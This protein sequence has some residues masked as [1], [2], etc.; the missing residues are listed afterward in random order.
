[1]SGTA[2]R[3]Y[4]LGTHDEELARLGLQHRVWRPTALAC[5]HRAGVTVGSRVLDVG[6]GPGFAAVDLAEIVGPTG[7]VVAVERSARFVAAGRQACAARGLAHV[8]YHELDL[9]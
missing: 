4:V 9:M 5:W 2:D 8:E 3:E 1:M 6:A 7:R